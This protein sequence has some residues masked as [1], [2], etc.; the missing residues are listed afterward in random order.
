MA[1]VGQQVSESSVIIGMS[2]N[3]L[4]IANPTT[5]QNDDDEIAVCWSYLDL[6]RI[7]CIFPISLSKSST[8]TIPTAMKIAVPPENLESISNLEPL[9]LWS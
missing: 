4:H 5:C 6:R 1:A 9:S 8:T 7:G 3:I 2:H